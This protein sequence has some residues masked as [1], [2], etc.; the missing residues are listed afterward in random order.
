ME[1]ISFYTD[2]HIPYE[3]VRQLRENG[4]EV[5]RC[6]DVGLADVS[7]EEHLIYAAEHDHVLITCDHGFENIHWRWMTEGKDHSGIIYCRMSALCTIGTILGNA[8]LIYE[9]LDGKTTMHNFFW[10]VEK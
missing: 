8:L 7:D 1:K 6:Q 3:V 9:D 5:V 10:R 2:T 4:A